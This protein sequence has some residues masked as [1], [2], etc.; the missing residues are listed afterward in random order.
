MDSLNTANNRKSS[1]G[2]KSGV[3][4]RL[5][6]FVTAGRQFVGL[7]EAQP[8]SDLTLQLAFL[9]TCLREEVQL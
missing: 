5:L 9:G 3:L 6:S 2:Y 4:G 1:V 7:T 8:A